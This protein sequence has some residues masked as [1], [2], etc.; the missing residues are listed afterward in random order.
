MSPRNP[1][2]T[3]NTSFC[4][5]KW[6]ARREGEQL[7]LIIHELAHAL[8]DTPMEHGPKWGDAC[9]SAGTQIAHATARKRLRYD[10]G[11]TPVPAA[12]IGAIGTRRTNAKGC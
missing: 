11:P 4:C 12:A 6:L 7:E 3:I 5:D 2:V 8:S 1:E 9:A 10:L